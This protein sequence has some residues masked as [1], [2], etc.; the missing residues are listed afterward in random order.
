MS[1][2]TRRGFLLRAGGALLVAAGCR[3]GEG[4]RRGPDAGEAAG[5]STA[6]CGS[7]V[8]SHKYG[9]TRIGGRPERVVPVTLRDQD[10]L[11]ALGVTPAA[12]Q[13]DSAYRGSYLGWPWVPESLGE[14]D[15]QTLRV[16]AL[17]FERIAALRPDLIVGAASGLAD[18]DY[19][20]LERIAPTLAQSGAYVDYGVPWQEITRTLGRALC[21]EER[22]EDRVA[23][24]EG[25]LAA[26]RRKHPELEGAAGVVALVG[27]PDGSFWVYGPQDSRGR[28]LRSLGM[29][30][31]PELA[32]LTRGRFG[33][34][35]SGERVDLLDTD[36]LVWLSSPEQRATLAE[37]PVYRE[38]PV[39]REG[40]VVHLDVQGPLTAAVT[41]TSALN[42]GYLVEKLV[43]R[44]AAAVR[45]AGHP[46]EA[47]GG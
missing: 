36:V 10:T 8:L 6:G 5:N 37:H 18:D 43:P 26:G 22:A 39:V 27:G 23:E 14:A 7:R 46:A 24:V 44:I 38:L 13:E 2:L 30:L 15:H 29:T 17:N 41:N 42:L 20:T 21:R 3:G 9:E 16:R 25:T 34:R 33:A 35:L 31:P 47:S 19:R 28:F 11:L 40:R 32:E 4:N 1:R 12:I 45:G